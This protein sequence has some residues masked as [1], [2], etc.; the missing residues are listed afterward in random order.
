[1]SKLLKISVFILLLL[2]VHLVFAQTKKE[3]KAFKKTVNQVID[4]WQTTPKDFEDYEKAYTFLPELG[5]R[6]KYY[7]NKKIIN[8]ISIAKVVGEPVFLSGPHQ[9]Q[10]IFDSGDFGRYNP[11]F[12][13]KLNI[14]LT[15]L[16]ADKKFRE[17]SAFFYE[18]ELKKYLQ[19]MMHA[20]EHVIENDEVKI[21]AIEH[22]K[23]HLKDDASNAGYLMKAHFSEFI[24]H[25]V[26]AGYD[27]HELSSAAVFWVRRAM[28]GTDKEFYDLMLL[29]VET[30]DR[31]F[32][33]RQ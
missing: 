23:M 4:K 26:I 16:L 32:T 13:K 21:D 12:L 14:L 10:M 18:I 22:Y 1:M 9:K 33:E 17:S 8:L 27:W 30:Y 3:H 31:P 11:K 24:D 25:F 15:V 19:T 2:T 7:L 28:D 20:Y 29:M 5:V 6:G